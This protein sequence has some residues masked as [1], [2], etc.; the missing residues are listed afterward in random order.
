MPM[1][2]QERDEANMKRQIAAE[3]GSTKR[4][5]SSENE[6][7][8]L[9]LL[10][11]VELFTSV[12]V[13]YLRPADLANV[14]RTC[15]R[16]GSARDGQPR[17]LA[18]EAAHRMFRLLATE[19]E[20]STLPRY[21]DESEIALLRQLGFLREPLGWEQLVG[22]YIQ[23]TSAGSKSGVLH[24]TGGAGSSALCNLVM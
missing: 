22:Y 11:D 9:F 1:P 19:W 15:S 12:I 6:V 17:S 24:H 7:D 23:H 2:A 13:S 10:F 16:F 8:S 4:V 20:V 18:N 5:K 3:D 21:D 14:G